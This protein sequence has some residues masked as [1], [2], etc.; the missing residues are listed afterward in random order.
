MAALGAAELTSQ[1]QEMQTDIS[2]MQQTLNAIMPKIDEGIQTS[3]QIATDI[4]KKL[5]E[6]V[7]PIVEAKVIDTIVRLND[8]HGALAAALDARVAEL[9]AAITQ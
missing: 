8:H 3:Q 2:Q 1:M 5:A 9:K 4:G 7:N 6:H